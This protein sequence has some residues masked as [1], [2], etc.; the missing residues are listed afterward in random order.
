MICKFRLLFAFGF[1]IVSTYARAAS[2]L[3]LADCISR[4]KETNPTLIEAKAAVDQARADLMGAYAFYYPSI[5][6]SSG[7]LT[8]VNQGKFS[9]GIGLN[10]TLYRG[11]SARAGVRSAQAKVQLTE[12]NY[13]LAESEVI[14]S[15]KQAFFG[16]LQKQ[17]QIVSVGDVLKR[18]RE[19]LAIIRLKYGG[20]TES[21]PAVKETEANVAQGEYDKLKADEELR[22]GKVNLNL[23][24]GRPRAEAVSL[25]Y[26]DEE[27]AFPPVEKMIED[28]YAHRPEIGIGQSNKEALAAEASKAKSNYLPTLSVSSSVDLQGTNFLAQKTGWSAGVNLS[29]PIFDG[30]ST[31]AQVLAATLALKNEDTKI[32]A[33]KQT[34]AEEIEQAASNYQLAV[35]NLEIAN[36]S[37]AAEE[38]MYQLTKLKYEQGL[39]D[40]FFLQQ[41]ENSLTQ[42]EYSLVTAQFN[43]RTSRAQLQKAWGGGNQ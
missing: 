20:G 30:F 14:L 43:L 18:R 3:T 41:K 10:Y 34:I 9:S 19:D 6:L 8:G 31:R 15:V 28:A 1:F 27:I 40:Y 4:A 23:L 37:L 13:R 2:S 7:Y 33:I 11:G 26:Q 32:L 17:E 25:S 35:K 5:D 16:I 29:L 42:A 24:I 12:E 21:S 22:L 39:T 38:A 36:L